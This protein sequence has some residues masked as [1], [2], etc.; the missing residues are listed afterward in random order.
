[1]E[2]P[3]LNKTYT[4][5]INFQNGNFHDVIGRGS[6][7]SNLEQAAETAEEI[8]QCIQIV[9]EGVDTGLDTPVLSISDLQE[10]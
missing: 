6:M 5:F 10:V 7:H 8:D 3:T 2:T 1:M 4:Y 9:D